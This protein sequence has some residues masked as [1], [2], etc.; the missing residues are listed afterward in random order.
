V[1][2]GAYVLSFFKKMYRSLRTAM[3]PFHFIIAYLNAI[4]SIFL[5]EAGDMRPW[6]LSGALQTILGK[7]TPL[8][9]ERESKE[10]LAA[11]SV[12]RV[13]VRVSPCACHACS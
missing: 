7:A 4:N 3:G 11:L 6:A 5:S 1:H 10:A 2:Q 13:C 9:N 8:I 12:I